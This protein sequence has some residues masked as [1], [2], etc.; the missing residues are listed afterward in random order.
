MAFQLSESSDC[1][2]SVLLCMSLSDS[3]WTISPVRVSI[4]CT[5]FVWV[6]LSHVCVG[7][8][9]VL[10]P[11]C[12]VLCVFVSFGRHSWFELVFFREGCMVSS[13]SL[14]VITTVL[15]R[16][17]LFSGMERVCWLSVPV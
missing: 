15:D 5:V 11:V 1:S 17:L 14:S 9:S 8:E 12:S 7:L 6:C 16:L 3:G 10:P 2:H 13:S 4:V